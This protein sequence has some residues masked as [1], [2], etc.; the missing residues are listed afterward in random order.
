MIAARAAALVAVAAGLQ[1]GAARAEEP[2]P[3]LETKL[4]EEAV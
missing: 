4:Q 1:I 2:S 3:G